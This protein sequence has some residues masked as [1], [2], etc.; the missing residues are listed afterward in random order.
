MTPPLGDCSLQAGQELQAGGAGVV[1][2]QR[3][4]HLRL[5]R[6]QER[7]QLNQI[8]GE[9]PLVIVPVAQDPAGAAI[10]GGRLAGMG[11]GRGLA[12]R[13]AGHG[14]D[15]QVLQALLTRVG[16]HPD[17]PPFVP[18]DSMFNS[19]ST[20]V[21]YKSCFLSMSYFFVWS[22]IRAP[23]NDP[24]TKP[25]RPERDVL[26]ELGG[27]RLIVKLYRAFLKRFPDVP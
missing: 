21:E 20:N 22:W 11:D 5:V 9:L 18:D 24:S 1:Q 15:D 2:I 25:L 17:A 3:F 13:L 19:P 7:C 27:R 26:S 10:Q 14:L 6:L 23:V 8:E 16:L 12:S 4:K